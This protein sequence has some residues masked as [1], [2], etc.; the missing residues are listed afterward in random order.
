MSKLSITIDGHTFV[1]ESPP[2][3]RTTG[4]IT[5]RVDGQSVQV[6]TPET[7]S[8]ELLDWLIV[9]RRPYEVAVDPNLRWMRSRF[10]L[11]QIE[12]RDLEATVARPA[13]GDGRIKAP[14]PGLI[15]RVL[16]SPGEAVELGQPLL[17][18]EAMKMENE[19][20][21]PRAGRVTQ[22]HVAPGQSVTLGVV[23]AE[24]E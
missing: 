11:H 18:L 19:I 6:L 3:H 4:A 13:S 10:G 1:V 5:V 2:L 14:I 7:G 9:E 20:R 15:T 24:V 21:A 17:V 16:V 8:P 12:V 23:V 22:I